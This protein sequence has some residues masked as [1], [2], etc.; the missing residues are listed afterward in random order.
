MIVAIACSFAAAPVVA[1]MV[2]GSTIQVLLS[3]NRPAAALLE[4]SRYQNATLE[5]LNSGFAGTDFA[6]YT[7]PTQ[8]PI[9]VRRR[10]ALAATARRLSPTDSDKAL[11]FAVAAN[12]TADAQRLLD[13]GAHQGGDGFLMEN[14]LTHIAARFA[15]PAML[16]ILADAGSGLDDWHGPFGREGDGLAANTPLMVAISSGRRDNVA[17][18]IERGADVD[19][20]NEGGTSAL[21][22]AMISCGGD[23]DLVTQLIRAGARPNERAQRIAANLGFDL[24]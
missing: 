18:L 17:W 2:S 14:S 6:A 24:R 12:S 10:N 21:V 15:D 16:G 3:L 1:G 5:L 7:C 20:T 13:G 23:Q 9:V 4:Y 8:S 11:L 22:L 19:A